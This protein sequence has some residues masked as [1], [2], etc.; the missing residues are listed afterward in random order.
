MRV[1]GLETE[2]GVSATLATAAGERRLGPDE[3]GRRLFRPVAEE[4]ATTSVFLRNGGRLYLD[5]GS[6]PE[7]ATAEC[8]RLG[9][10]LAQDRAGDAIVATLAG[11]AAALAAAEGERVAFRVFKNNVDHYGNSY[12]SHENYQIARELDLPDLAQALS[13]FLVARQLL[14]GAGRIVKEG[15]SFT[16]AVSQRADVLW[17]ALAAGSTRARPLVNTRAEPHAD[18]EPFRRLHVISGDSTIAEAATLVR[19]MS[20]DAVLRLV[21]RGSGR[22]LSSWA[23]RDT[24]GAVRAVSRDPRGRA[25]YD[26]ASGGTA[27]A[28]AVLSDVHDL[29]AELDEPDPLWRRALGQ[30]G[31]TVA[32]LADDDPDRVAAEVDW[33]AKRRLLLGYAERHGLRLGDERLARLDLA[34]HELGGPV[35]RALGRG[36]LQ[37]RVTTDDQVD[38]AVTTP[39]VTR[40]LLRGRLVA[41]AGRHHRATTVDWSSFTVKDL[42]GPATVVLGDPAAAA[43][44]AVDDLV[45]RMRTEPRRLPAPGVAGTAGVRAAEGQSRG[46][47]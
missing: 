15:H 47:G 6:H 26:L 4:L 36:G 38:R 40:A 8:N 35:Q 5:V 24:A 31:R 39:P 34:Y 10:L 29:A 30:W 17:D 46:V 21:E 42:P 32:A 2:Y 33:V 9:D 14:C 20:L 13:G 18:P 1:V 12:G 16:Y 37:A 23:P 45:E 7:Y 44:P 28:L 11:R 41:A 19:V 22:R 25:T 27:S 3:V 43:D